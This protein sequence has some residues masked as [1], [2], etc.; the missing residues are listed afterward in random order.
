MTYDK[1]LAAAIDNAASVRKLA[2]A[3]PVAEA[4]GFVLATDVISDT[5]M[6][7]FNR[8]VCDG[9]AARAHD[10]AEA[11]VELAVVE[12]A[13]LKIGAGQAARVVAGAAVPEGADVVVPPEETE[14]TGDKAR[15]L[16]TNS[17]VRG[18]NVAR[19]GE[20]AEKGEVVVPAKTRVTPAMVGLLAAVGA[21]EVT[22]FRPPEIAYFATGGEIVPPD[23]K[24]GLGR[25]RDSNSLVLEALLKDLGFAGARLGIV[26]DDMGAIRDA[27]RRGFEKDVLLIT[28]AADL[29][30]EAL[31]GDGVE[32]IFHQVA[33]KPGTPVFCGRKGDRIIFGLPGNPVSVFTVFE[34]MVRPVLLALCGNKRNRPTFIKATFVGGRAGNDALEQFLPGIL[35]GGEGIATVK[36]TEWRGSG[37][38]D[39]AV[40]GQLLRADS[41][42]DESA[43]GRRPGG[44]PSLRRVP[45]RKRLAEV[46][47]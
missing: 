29:A 22:V 43:G 12:A 14:E 45:M 3:M 25:V 7:P 41:G 4:M 20:Y 47:Q 16:V 31:A 38:R 21:A 39:G 42:R 19:M 5:D 37:R 15:V 24:P 6:P 35:S 17:P 2:V 40:A 27:A 34:L 8:A 13:T 10:L 18:A 44:S 36:T 23:S 33:I 1:A 46:R 9:F 26:A 30:P 32:T 28:G 11:P